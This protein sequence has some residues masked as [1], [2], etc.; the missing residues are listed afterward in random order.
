[1]VLGTTHPFT[2]SLQWTLKFQEEELV[3][4][5]EVR[6]TYHAVVCSLLWQVS[7]QAT[8]SNHEGTE[9]ESKPAGKQNQCSHPK[10]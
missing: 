3:E 5:V 10:R 7:I 6:M 1:M 2:I 8:K 9:E 4:D